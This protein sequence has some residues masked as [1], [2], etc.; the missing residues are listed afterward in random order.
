MAKSLSPNPVKRQFSN[1]LCTDTGA[2]QVCVRSSAECGNVTPWPR[3]SVPDKTAVR[4]PH[5]PPGNHHTNWTLHTPQTVRS[6]KG[7]REPPAKPSHAQMRKRQPSGVQPRPQQ[8]HMSGTPAQGGFSFLTASSEHHLLNSLTVEQG[9]ANAFQKG[10]GG[11]YCRLCHQEGR[12]VSVH[13]QEQLDG[14]QWPT[15]NR[16]A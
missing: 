6:W 4:L 12:A 2:V 8:S 14:Q 11:K 15:A 16:R 5:R 13:A 9:L 7:S 10:S 3:G 1:L